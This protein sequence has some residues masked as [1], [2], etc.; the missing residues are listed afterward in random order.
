MQ[1]T[2]LDWGNFFNQALPHARLWRGENDA[3][4]GQ[5]LLK[6]WRHEEANL[7]I[8]RDPSGVIIGIPSLY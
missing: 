6:L 7:G 2:E 3:T 5:L 4:I 1:A 8:S